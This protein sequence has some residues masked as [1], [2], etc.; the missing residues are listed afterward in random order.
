MN[1]QKNMETRQM[2]INEDTYL[3]IFQLVILRLILIYSSQ[4]LHDFWQTYPLDLDLYLLTWMT[5]SYRV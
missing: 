2:V 5:L 3:L 4:V 1:A